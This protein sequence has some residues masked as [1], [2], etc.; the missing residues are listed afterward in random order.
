[1]SI[2]LTPD[3]SQW[4][5]N[6]KSEYSFIKTSADKSANKFQIFDEAIN[7]NLVYKIKTRCAVLQINLHPM[8]LEI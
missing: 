2:P 5:F 6:W 1:M 4:I 7:K 3:A 8:F